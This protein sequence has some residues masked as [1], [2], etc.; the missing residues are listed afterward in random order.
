MDILGF[1]R[2]ELM[3]SPEDMHDA[4]GGST[5]CSARPSSHRNW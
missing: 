1:N 5:T 3:M 4:V 2:V